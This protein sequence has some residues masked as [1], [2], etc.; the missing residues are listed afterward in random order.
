MGTNVE[1]ARQFNSWQKAVLLLVLYGLVYT[2][3]FKLAAIMHGLAEFSLWYPAAGFRFALIFIF[4][5]RFGLLTII[6][7]IIAQGLMGQWGVLYKDPFNMVVGIGGPSFIYTCL[8][9]GLDRLRY[10]SA[11]LTNLSQIIWFCL[12]AMIAPALAAP[13]M[14]WNAIYNARMTMGEFYEA[15]LSF[16]IGDLVGVLMVA[17]LVLLTIN[18]INKKSTNV[19]TKLRNCTFAFE[20]LFALTF[21]WMTF[22]YM[23]DNSFSLHWF[24]LLVP[25]IGIPYRYGFAASAAL[26]LVINVIAVFP[27]SAMAVEARF[28]LQTFLA[29]SSFMGLIV[30][31]LITSRERDKERLTE[32]LQTI[33]QMDRRSM[34]GDMATKVFHEIDQPLSTMNLITQGAIAQLNS[35]K[36]DE[37]AL[38]RIM[39]LSEQENKRT[40]ALIKSMKAFV[41]TGELVKTDT[42]VQDVIN[43]V[44][45]MTDMLAE[46]EKVTVVYEASVTELSIH[47][48][49]ILIGQAVLNLARNSIEAMEGC[50]VKQL[51]IIEG[52]K[53][54]ETYISITDTGSGFPDDFEIAQTTKLDGM[55]L[56]LQIVNDIIKSHGGY[57]EQKGSTSTFYLKMG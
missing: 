29:M 25:I 7:E 38:R 52:Y 22:T 17:P 1:I 13:L 48:D 32:N 49:K 4:G 55:G 3:F 33:A 54:R 36:L 2:A 12:A 57:L 50:E 46:Q 14:T 53:G 19:F 5:W 18:A 41:K 27:A 26:T 42:T 23:A 34:V 24:P 21:A 6:P 10:V 44:R 45:T 16:W 28:E 31:G 20:F 9:V 30:G 15:A 40:Q 56:G 35:G 47:V 8:L 37:D 43:S 39:E 51:T 11:R